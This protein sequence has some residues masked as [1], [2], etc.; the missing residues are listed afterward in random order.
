[1]LEGCIVQHGEWPI[2]CNNSKWSV[3]FKNCIKINNSLLSI[4]TLLWQFERYNTYP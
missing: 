3:V 1:M 2:F 4:M